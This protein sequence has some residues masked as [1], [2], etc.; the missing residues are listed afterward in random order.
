[1][2]GKCSCPIRTKEQSH[3]L[4]C[5]SSLQHRAKKRDYKD[6]IVKVKIEKE[7]YLKA[8]VKKIFTP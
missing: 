2:I 7:T 5:S 1:M 4:R 8:I 3:P 6:K